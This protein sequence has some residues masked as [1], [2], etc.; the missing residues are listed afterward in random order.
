MEITIGQSIILGVVQGLTELLPIS[1]SAHLK[2]I[3]IIFGW[4]GV[5]D[6]FDVALHF[7][8][9]FAIVLFFFK[10]WINL[11]K[12]GYNQVVKKE[13]TKEGKMFWY[14][15]AATIPGGAIGFALDYL[16]EHNKLVDNFLNA[17]V[18]IAI[19]LIVMGIILYIVDKVCS[20]KTKYEDMTFLIGLSQ[21]LAFIPGVSRSGVTMTTGRAL[22]VSRE[23]VAKYSFLLS[24]PIVVGATIFKLGDFIEF[25]G[26]ASTTGVIAFIL[27]V[28]V[29][30]L[31]G[32]VVIKFLLEY[33]KKGSFK[34]FAI[35]RCV[36]GI[37][38]LI[39]AFSNNVLL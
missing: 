7:G 39:W 32:V 35:Y 10:D 18:V 13:K 19:A 15:V 27:G 2:L 34:V 24:T 12:S 21:A 5:P 3:P 1:S 25:L 26:M 38:V 30:F 37:A 28:L 20:S 6:S 8:T 23:S 17:P 36:L 29:S 31:V 33:L 11:I 4:S 14:L 16:S 22:G 9:L